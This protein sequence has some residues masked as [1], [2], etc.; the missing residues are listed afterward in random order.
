MDIIVTMAA[1]MAAAVTCLTAAAHQPSASLVPAMEN[2]G[3][4]MLITILI[5]A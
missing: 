3:N 1:C 4:K 2:D 5:D